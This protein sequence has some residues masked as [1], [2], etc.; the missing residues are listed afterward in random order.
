MSEKYTVL[1]KMS[2]RRLMEVAAVPKVIP[3]TKMF[4]GSRVISQSLMR[5][6]EQTGIS[7]DAQDLRD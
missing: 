2:V 6:F 3:A 1:K 4:G 7:I 5:R